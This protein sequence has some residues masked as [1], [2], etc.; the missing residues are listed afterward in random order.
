MSN[1]TLLQAAQRIVVPRVV[2]VL[3]TIVL[4]A[5]LQSCG[6]GGGS[7]PPPSPRLAKSGSLDTEFG[8][9]GVALI[10]P[11]PLGDSNRFTDVLPMAD[12][13]LLLG[14][15]YQ[16]HGLVGYSANWFALRLDA[17]GRRDPAFGSG[18]I[19]TYG[20]DPFAAVALS[21]IRTDNL[22]Q[23]LFIGQHC[24]AI[25]EQCGPNDV[26][27]TQYAIEVARFS[28]RGTFD[29]GYGTSGLFSKLG[30]RARPLDAVV[31]DDGKLVVY[32]TLGGE[33]AHSPA[34]ET[35]FRVTR[36]GQLDAD[37]PAFPADT[38]PLTGTYPVGGPFNVKL[39]REPDGKLMIMSQRTIARFASNGELDTRFG[40]F[41]WM[42]FARDLVDV[43]VSPSNIFTVVSRETSEGTVTRQLLQLQPQGIPVHGIVSNLTELGTARETSVAMQ[44]DGR[45]LIAGIS[46]GSVFVARRR[47]D[48]GADTTFG[49]GGNG[50][51]LTP[52]GTEVTSAQLVV[53][54][55]GRIVVA[56]MAD[57]K[58]YVVRYLQ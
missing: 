36:D 32:T 20:V 3:S 58:L 43:A 4:F 46:G 31:Q 8:V 17:A 44:A 27:Q 55:A 40:A 41:G 22:G 38:V 28:E 7:D 48:G 19:A 47:T 12:G 51:V 15:S 23:I 37:F 13:G 49:T 52:L 50:V 34:T 5:T 54:A 57:S 10:V 16:V 45:I 21:H 25:L 33:A 18:G 9:N 35:W 39:F 30:Y 53:D 29:A 11:Y 56:G 2:L 26:G 14:G 1:S 42:S 24:R 6:G